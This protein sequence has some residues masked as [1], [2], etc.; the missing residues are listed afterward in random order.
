MLFVDDSQRQRFE[1]DIVL[2]QRVGADQEI[3]LAGF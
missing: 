3:D 1:D 2:D